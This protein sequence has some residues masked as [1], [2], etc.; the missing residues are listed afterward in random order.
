MAGKV[1]SKWFSRPGLEECP[2]K[3]DALQPLQLAVRG[4]AFDEFLPGVS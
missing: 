3:I 4:T 1:S 2:T